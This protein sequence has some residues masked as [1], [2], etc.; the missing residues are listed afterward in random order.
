MKICKICN[1]EITKKKKLVYCSDECLSIGRKLIIEATKEKKRINKT[2]SRNKWKPLVIEL[3]NTKHDKKVVLS[4]LPINKS[5]CTYVNLLLRQNNLCVKEFIKQK[6]C[7]GVVK[8][9]LVVLVRPKDI[10]KLFD[11]KY[12]V[13]KKNFRTDCLNM[14]K[15]LKIVYGLVND[16]FEKDTKSNTK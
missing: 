5:T 12:E 15:T 10:K 2:Q 6:R 11:F 3:D 7:D 1:N 8:D 14:V 13:Y 4:S 16:Y 9:L